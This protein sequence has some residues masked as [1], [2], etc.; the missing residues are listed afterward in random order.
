MLCGMESL[1]QE[2]KDLHSLPVSVPEWPQ[3]H[4][5]LEQI[6]LLP[7]SSFVD[8]KVFGLFHPSPKVV[9]VKQIIVERALET[10]KMQ[11]TW[12]RFIDWPG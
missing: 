9:K 1:N 6:T 7:C 11:Q 3:G 2:S 12:E 8:I 4:N 5:D 10:I